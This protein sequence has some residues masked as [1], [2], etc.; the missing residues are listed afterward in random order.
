M[1]TNR[2]SF[3]V[4]SW[5]KMIML[6]MKM[7]RY[8]GRRVVFEIKSLIK[9]VKNSLLFNKGIKIC[10]LFLLN[11]FSHNNCC[12]YM[13]SHIF[14]ST[15]IIAGNGRYATCNFILRFVF[16]EMKGYLPHHGLSDVSNIW[17]FIVHLVYHALLT[18]FLYPV[19]LLLKHVSFI[20]SLAWMQETGKV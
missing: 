18:T 6:M 7:C 11:D 19:P 15:V 4:A 3:L 17:P 1:A 2:L 20:L 13:L 14:Q 8:M 9:L 12:S 5:W 10:L 16:V